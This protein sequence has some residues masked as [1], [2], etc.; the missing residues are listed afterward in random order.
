MQQL[1]FNEP[2]ARNTDPITSHEAAVD[3]SRFSGN[4]RSKVLQLLYS[5]GALTDYEL[6]D[7]TGLQQNSIGKRRGECSQAGLVQAL[8]DMDGN[9]V[10]G[11]TPSGSK[12]IRW[13]LTSKGVE[14]VQG[15]LS[16]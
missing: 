5:F 3:A 9:P 8:T 11:R 6:S 10:K 16:C 7:K 2:L 13:T 15:G 12:A 14:F 4:N 1:T